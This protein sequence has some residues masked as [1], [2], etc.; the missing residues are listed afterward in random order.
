MIKF[1]NKKRKKLI[2][3]NECALFIQRLNFILALIYLSVRLRDF[4]QIISQII[5]SSRLNFFIFFYTK[6][7]SQFDDI[8]YRQIQNI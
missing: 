3:N 8:K 2:R 7:E 5:F 4:E 1:T 6:N